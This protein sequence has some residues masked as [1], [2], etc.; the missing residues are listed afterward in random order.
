M[1][2]GHAL[3]AVLEDLQTRYE[4]FGDVRGIGLMQAAELVSDRERK[5][6]DKKTRDLLL[7]KCFGDGLLLFNCDE[8]TIRFCPPL[9]VDENQI[10]ISLEILESVLKRICS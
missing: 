2:Q 1:V 5:T 3:R 8:S 9:I 10:N 4:C 6:K 7:E